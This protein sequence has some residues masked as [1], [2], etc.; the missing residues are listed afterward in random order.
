[1][2]LFVYGTLM[3]D[4][5]VARLIGRRLRKEAA[6]LP[7]Y[8]KLAP[9]GNYPYI[10]SDAAASVTGFLL[11]GLDAAALAALDRYEDEGR[12]YRRTQV[13]VTVAGTPRPA[14][15]YVGIPAALASP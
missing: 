4:D 11:R 10:V 2:D 5:L 13:V 14:M 6:A 7:G 1:M 15:T 12:L 8:R 3:D 9:A